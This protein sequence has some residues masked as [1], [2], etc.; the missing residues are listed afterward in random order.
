MCRIDKCQINNGGCAATATCTDTA[1]S[2]ACTCNAGYTGDGKTCSSCGPL[3]SDGDGTNDDCDCQPFNK[4]VG[5]LVAEVCDGAD[6]NC[7][8]QVDE[9]D[10]CGKTG[11]VQVTV[12]NG[13]TKAVLAG[14]V[15]N[16]KPA[17]KCSA[18]GDLAAAV[19]TANTPA[20]GKV[21]LTPPPGAYCIEVT[22]ATYK[23]TIT[24]DFTLLLGQVKPLIVPLQLTT[25]VDNLVSIC[26]IVTDATTKQP[27]V[28]AAV[29][30]GVTVEDNVVGTAKT[31]ATG[32]YCIFSLKSV[33]TAIVKVL[34]NGYVSANKTTT[35]PVNGVAI[36]DFQL[37][38]SAAGSCY[39]NN[40]EAGVVGWTIDPASVGNQWQVI[41]NAQLIKNTAY[42]A[43]VNVWPGEKC[44]PNPNDIADTCV[45]CG[46]ASQTACTP[47]A[48][49]LPRATSGTHAFW[50]GAVTTGNFL[51]TSGGTCAAGSGGEG[52][53][54]TGTAI[55]PEQTL[56]AN[57]SAYILRFSY[58]YEIEGVAPQYPT[59]DSM[60][61]Y[62]SIN[63]GAFAAVGHLNPETSFNYATP[64]AYTSGGGSQPPTWSVREIPLAAAKAGDKI[65]IKLEFKTGDGNFNAFRGWLVDDLSV[66]GVGCK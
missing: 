44:V 61:L 35:P 64:D 50:Y 26:G 25:T 22:L 38:V 30:A 65:R 6:N 11:I 5:P 37:S 29:S 27:I 42:P 3:D 7:N 16:V 52:T 13:S 1:G 60:N 8:G 28:G 41:D 54:N 40:F 9:G 55:M 34:A 48:G 39:T 18:T 56:P 62:L 53:A 21:T 33:T 15:V 12:I 59:Y 43:C 4:N 24:G 45:I 46:S 49:S 57:S 66:M 23:K 14:A 2:V 32:Q 36:V 19:V 31:D 10:I 20:N 51:G 47:A 63:G 58:W 17:G